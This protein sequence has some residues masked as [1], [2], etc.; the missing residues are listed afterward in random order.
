M[1]SRG[2]QESLNL[3]LLCWMLKCHF[4]KEGKLVFKPGLAARISG[5][6]HNIGIVK[7]SI[8]P[9]GGV[10]CMQIA[11]YITLKMLY[12]EEMKTEVSSFFFFFI[13]LFNISAPLISVS[14]YSAPT[15][16]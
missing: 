1:Y 3:L 5:W 8:M 10:F 4:L 16:F 2:W 11:H 12:K 7:A 14:I 9:W 13:L 6:L 15:V